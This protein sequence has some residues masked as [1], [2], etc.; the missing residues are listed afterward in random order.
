MHLLSFESRTREK[1]NEVFMWKDHLYLHFLNYITMD[2]VKIM[3][4]QLTI[5]HNDFNS[6]NRQDKIVFLDV[7]IFSYFHCMP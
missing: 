1:L 7:H 4:V 5:T 6:V 2:S 3:I